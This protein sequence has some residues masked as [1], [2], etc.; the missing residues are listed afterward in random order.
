MTILYIETNFLMSIATGRD[1]EAG[2]LLKAPPPIRIVMPSVCFIEAMSA[3]EQERK[4]LGEFTGSLQGRIKQS[5]RDRTS[6]HV[7]PLIELLDQAFRKAGDLHNDIERRLFDSLIKISEV[8]ERVEP[9][10]EIV[11]KSIERP[12]IQRDLTDNLILHCILHHAANHQQNER[13]FLTGNSKDFGSEL[14]KPMLLQAGVRHF[15][16]AKS[17]LGWLG[18]SSSQS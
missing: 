16:E 10:P 2:Q 14:V 17:F 1:P 15:S 7:N 4:H 9:L 6:E 13:A 12:I 18:S 8:A 3:L 5:R 11:R